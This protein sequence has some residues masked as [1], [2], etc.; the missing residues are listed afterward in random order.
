MYKQSIR[1]MLYRVSVLVITLTMIVTLLSPLSVQANAPVTDLTTLSPQ[2]ASVPSEDHTPDTSPETA[3]PTNNTSQAEPLIQDASS[4]SLILNPSN[5][6]TS[7]N[8]TA[9][10]P[11]TQSNVQ[12]DVSV[13]NTIGSNASSG[14]ASADQNTTVGD[15]TSGNATALAT[16][17]SLL[18]SNV[19]LN[20]SQPITF[21]QDVTGN[22][23]GD[24]LVDPAALANSL[25]VTATPLFG[26]PSADISIS[27]QS[28]INNTINVGASSGDASAHQNTTTGNIQSGSANAVANIVNII[29]SAINANQSFIG[30]INIYGNLKGNILVPADFVDSVLSTGE[31][32]NDSVP[33][34]TADNDASV[35]NTVNTNAQSG[36]A[37]AADNTTTGTISSG[38]ANTNVTIL[39][40]TRNETIGRNAL[41][42]FVNVLGSWVGLILDAPAGTT[43]ANLGGNTVQSTATA[44]N[45]N[46]DDDLRIDNVINVS[47]SSGN[48]TAQENTTAGNVKTGNANASVNLVNILNSQIS[49]SDWF[50]IL[51][52]N[53]FGEWTGNFGTQTAVD[54]TPT[55]NPGPN[56]SWGTN[57]PGTD[58][59]PAVFRFMPNN[60]NINRSYTTKLFRTTA[61]K[62]DIA[63]I[64]RINEMTHI[65][66]SVL[67]NKTQK[68]TA[69]SDY[70]TINL[71]TDNEAIEDQGLHWWWL[72]FILLLTALLAGRYYIVRRREAREH[73]KEKI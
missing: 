71:Q 35:I 43:S 2:T 64:D 26:N 29:N 68:V 30:M 6:Q 72:P 45:L 31:S 10:T 5:P 15:I 11:T 18:Q 7:T 39:N 22:V 69:D 33:I 60:P 53:V 38:A 19:N 55:N 51:F 25:D 8:V 44:N 21:V 20:G 52:I 70:D 12:T 67:G 42:V 56:P 4:P 32:A 40:L 16:I 66:E 49:L 63:T 61:T 54:T 3:P 46:T 13:S 14:N 17:V 57:S 59:S 62:A 37:T 47:A 73:I 34:A 50:G 24:L 48:A 23:Q 27:T 36:T 41:L 9:N 1:P 65:D 28:T 58:S